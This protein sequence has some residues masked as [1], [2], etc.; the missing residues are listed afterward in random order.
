MCLNLF[1]KI[2]GKHIICIVWK[3]AISDNLMVN[4]EGKG[5]EWANKGLYFSVR[6]SN[7]C[8]HTRR[9]DIPIC[10]ITDVN[11]HPGLVSLS[12]TSTWEV[13]IS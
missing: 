10:V 3:Q 5:F 12:V 8:C 7:W 2:I 11:G 1:T 6:M 4:C 13:W 9:R